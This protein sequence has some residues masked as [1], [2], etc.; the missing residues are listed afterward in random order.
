[1]ILLSRGDKIPAV[2]VVQRL[3][4]EC[5]TKDARLFGVPELD[6][7]AIFGGGTR[8]AVKRA[9]DKLG[10]KDDGIV[11]PDTWEALAKIA[12]FRIV[13][14]VDRAIE[15]MMKKLGH[16]GV[17]K[18][19]MES[20][21]KDNPGKSEDAAHKYADGIIK[22]CER[23]VGIFR[24]IADNYRA[25]G[26]DPIEVT[27]MANPLNEIRGGIAARSRDGWKVAI[28][29][30]VGHGSAGRQ[31]IACSPFGSYT[32]DTDLLSVDDDDGPGEIAQTLA[33]NGMT[34][35]MAS[36]GCVELHG[37][38]IARKKKAPKPGDPP[39]LTG[40][41][42]IQALSNAVGRPATAAVNKQKGSG[43]LRQSVRFEGSTVTCYPSGHG[44]EQWFKAAA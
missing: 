38:S 28:L 23:E 12:K 6:E 5:R 43:T 16:A 2:G 17:R 32:I 24:M 37:C 44:A 9:Q 30:L 39:F 33:L 13:H 22:I 25:L 4:N 3:I 10:L 29:R 19:A 18:K 27:S 42:Y 14:V 34:V 36:F 15:H 7:D 41:P 1:M 8:G 31:I 21:A 26:G 35:K 11:G 20:F 40:V